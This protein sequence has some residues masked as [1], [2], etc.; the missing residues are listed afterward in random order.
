MKQILYI[1]P[2]LLLLSCGQKKAEKAEAKSIDVSFENYNQAETARNFNNWAKLGGDNKMLHRTE[3]SP[4]GPDAP[5]IRM[6]LDTL[7]SVG[8]YHNDGEMSVT[9]PESGL[10]QSI[11]ILDTDGYTPFF[12]TEPGTHPVKDDSEFLFIAVRTVVEDRHDKASFEKAF[13][14][15]KGIKVEGNGS[16]SYVMPAFNQEQLHALTAEYNKKMLES[17]ISFVYGDGETPVNEE[18]R[19]WSNAAGWGGM[20]VEV[21]VANT[22][23]TSEALAGDVPMQVTFKD[24]GNKFF[25]SFTIYDLNGYLLEG[26]THINSYT[27]KPNEDGTITVHFN[28]EDKINNITSGGKEFNYIVR[29]YGVSEAALD[30]TINPVK[31]ELAK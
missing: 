1:L 30:K 5:T 12:F 4:V 14:A 28:A 16:K 24:P 31:P 22:Y 15:Q 25:T 2:A 29:N 21:D 19:T 18:Q 20:K 27:W 17:G 3:L 9:M 13:A 23:N 26:N 7:Y 10:Y 8:V 6:N 11:M